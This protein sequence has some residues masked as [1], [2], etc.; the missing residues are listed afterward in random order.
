VG[1]VAASP[2]KKEHE[3]DDYEDE[4]H[5]YTSYEDAADQLNGGFSTLQDC[6]RSGNGL[7]PTDLDSCGIDQHS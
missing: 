3:H 4:A 7:R 1:V 5:D 2:A 6:G